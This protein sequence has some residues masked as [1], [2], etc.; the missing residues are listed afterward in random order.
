MNVLSLERLS[1]SVFN[2]FYLI[3]SLFSVLFFIDEAV[4]DINLP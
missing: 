4:F 3:I 2:W 1:Q